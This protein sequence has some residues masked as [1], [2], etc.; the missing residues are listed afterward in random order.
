M[1]VGY[2]AIEAIARIDTLDCD[3]K[4]KLLNRRAKVNLNI[5]SKFFNF[6]AAKYS[7]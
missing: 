3:S 4:L 5:V 6:G 1:H 2:I 7:I